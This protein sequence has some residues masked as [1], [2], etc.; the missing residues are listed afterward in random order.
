MNAASEPDRDCPLCPRL[1]DFIADWRQREPSWFN[2][3][4][5]TFLPPDGED[6]VE[7]LIVGLAPGLRGANRTGRPFTGDYAG[8]LLYSTMIAHGFARGE[9][10]ARPDDGL[11][12]VGTAITNAVRCVPPEN[13]PVGAEITTCRSF[14]VPTIARFP[15]LRAVLALGSI[16]H[17]STV[18]ALGGRVAAYPFKHGGRL[19]A[20]TVKLFSSYHCSRY[21]TN[22]GVLTEAMFVSVF[23][24]IQ[25]YLNSPT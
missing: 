3:P 5:P 7:L 2:A 23:A 14:L 25:N 22:T 21:N 16:A 9:F 8:D 12:L 4:V 20:G 18:R 17:Q 6:A 10:K 24:E 1:H 15:K 11:Q 19:E 13:K